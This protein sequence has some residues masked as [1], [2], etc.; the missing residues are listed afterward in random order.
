MSRTFR[1]KLNLILLVTIFSAGILQAQNDSV[2]YNSDFR[3]KDGIYLN[4]DAFRHNRPVQK[5]AI[6]SNYSREEIDFLRKTVSARTI[7]Y[8]DST[9]FTHELNP[10]KIWG[11]CENNSVYIRYNGDFNKIVVMGS[12]CHFTAMYTT[13]LSG[14]PTTPGGAS[15]GAPVESVQQY[16]LDIETGRV[17]DFVL[18]N[19]EDL[20]KRDEVLYKEFMELKK[21]KRRKMM[22]FYL[23]KYN[24]K[25][26]LY[27]YS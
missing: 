11:F 4:Y 6:V 5:S 26:G 7:T 19:M 12:I 1:H 10:G 13:Y 23:R 9:G 22:F 8:K 3:F 21:S 14:G 15:T 17:L 27:I 16:V 24:E 2:R 18:P 25:H 20:F